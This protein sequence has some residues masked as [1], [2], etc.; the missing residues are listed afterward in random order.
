MPGPQ[1]PPILLELAPH[2]ATFT[3]FYG[4]PRVRKYYQVI[5]PV[6][7]L[8]S[9]ISTST[10]SLTK[11]A[12]DGSVH[13]EIFV[14]SSTSSTT[15]GSISSSTDADVY[16]IVTKRLRWTTSSFTNGTISSSSST[17]NLDDTS[18][19]RIHAIFPRTT[20]STT[21]LNVSYSTPLTPTKPISRPHHHHPNNNETSPATSTT[22][23][24]TT[25]TSPL[26]CRIR[27][28]R[29]LGGG[30]RQRGIAGRRFAISAIQSVRGIGG[31]GGVGG[32]GRGG[33]GG[34]FEG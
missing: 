29:P 10:V 13:S 1:L 25:T 4:H 30:P 33:G 26:P 34:G 24:T 15:D 11:D 23:T 32:G 22:A 8:N 12:V 9:T 2:T 3:D 6:L 17:T 20:N 5:R 31:A 28:K 19:T 14:R 21:P 18:D 7:A 27:P 16:D